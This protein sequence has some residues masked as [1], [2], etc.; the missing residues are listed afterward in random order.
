[1]VLAAEGQRVAFVVDELVR[2]QEVVVKRLGKRL[3]HVRYVSGATLLPS[4]E[5][6]LI[7]NA[8]ELVAA[9]VAAPGGAALAEKL[10]AKAAAKRLRVLLADDSVT[11][12]ALEKSILEGAGYDVLVAVDGAEA[13]RLLQDHGA[14]V[15][16]SDVEMPRMDGFAL[17]EAI[18][19]VPRF[20]DLPVV[21][22][23][24]R[25]RQDDRARGLEA[26]ANAYL[27]KSGFDQKTLL[28]T[29]AQLIA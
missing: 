24:A 23:T 16:V 6:V 15:V 1:V 11:T 2:E 5:V 21:L 9:G 17:T 27:V 10:Q 25:E 19:R 14:D 29:I 28:S 7:L 3:E 12:R 18:R 4:G 8:P 26:G 22:V 20:R 13:W